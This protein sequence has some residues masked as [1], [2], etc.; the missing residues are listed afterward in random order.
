MRMVRDL[1]NTNKF[2]IEGMST[3]RILQGLFLQVVDFSVIVPEDKK[4]KKCTGQGIFSQCIISRKYQVSAL[5]P[6]NIRFD[7]QSIANRVFS[8]PAFS[9]LLL[10]FS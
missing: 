2:N 6:E 1:K 7:V 5:Y 8:L 3:R 9:P 4:A 10:C